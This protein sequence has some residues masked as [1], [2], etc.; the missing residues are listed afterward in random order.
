MSRDGGWKEW[1]VFILK[2]VAEQAIDAYDCAVKLQALRTRYHDQFLNRPAVG[3]VVDFDFEAPYLTA[4]RA[5]DATGRSR[6]AD[7]DVL[8][9]EGI[10]IR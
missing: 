9:A 2:A 3:D 8:E 7:Y 6:Q 1:L 5:I 4:T 10:V